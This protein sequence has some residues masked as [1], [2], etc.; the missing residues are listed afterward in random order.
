[1]RSNIFHKLELFCQNESCRPT[2]ARA[3]TGKRVTTRHFIIIASL[4][5]LQL[6]GNLPVAEAKHNRFIGTPRSS[7]TQTDASNSEN[8]D[9]DEQESE[10][11]SIDQPEPVNFSS[12]EDFSTSAESDSE[13]FSDEASVRQEP[14]TDDDL[15]TRTS[16]DDLVDHAHDEEEASSTANAINAAARVNNN[17]V[18]DITAA[19]TGAEIGVSEPLAVTWYREK[20]E[21][22]DMDAQYNL[23]MISETGFGIEKDEEAAVKWY[24]LAAKEGHAEAQLKLG[25]LYLLGL[26][27]PE[28]RIKGGK[29]VRTAARQD[30]R[31]AR[32]LSEKFLSKNIEGLDVNSTLMAVRTV[33]NSSNPKRAEEKLL[34]LI[35]QSEVQ[36]QNRP[37]KERFAGGI[38]G[39]GAKSGSVGNRVPDFLAEKKT[40]NTVGNNSLARIRRHAKEGVA[41][42]QYEWGLILEKGDQVPVDREHAVK[43]FQAAAEQNHP[44]GLYKL[45]IADMY[46]IGVPLDFVHGKE[47]LA[48]AARQNHPVADQLL[49]YIGRTPGSRN[50]KKM[51]SI[52]VAWQL[53]KAIE[54]K[55][56][57]A[58]LSLGYMFQNGWGVQADHNESTIWMN[59]AKTSGTTEA[60][61]AIRISKVNEMV[62]DGEFS[63]SMNR[64]MTRAIVGNSIPVDDNKKI[65][66]AVSRIINNVKTRAK[67][68]LSQ[69][70]EKQ[71]PLMLL[72]GGLVLGF[73]VFRIMRRPGNRHSHSA[74]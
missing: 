11:V 9:S 15:D 54:Q 65:A 64:E 46:G 2:P 62:D 72:G 23:A 43:W 14:L 73:M 34:V 36:S 13:S 68:L 71:K 35:A 67:D 27:A 57:N 70:A 1:M 8:G 40:E 33:Y 58:M 50:S 6:L 48:R 26:G 20:A 53:Q 42:A 24:S 21:Q 19:S 52:T 3:T 66:R 18:D 38:T 60:S 10:S 47:L 45:A 49:K 29:W 30:N 7:V 5:V 12:E 32:V 25:M 59:R 56:G 61:R 41:E 39:S 37:K 44:G 28:S 4:L 74:Y 31:F 51:L 55:N 69:D 16:P 63:K 17:R 22:G